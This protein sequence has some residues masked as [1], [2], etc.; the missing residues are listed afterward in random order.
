MWAESQ[1]KNPARKQVAGK[2][3]KSPKGQYPGKPNICRPNTTISTSQVYKLSRQKP[4]SQDSGQSNANLSTQRG[5]KKTSG[6]HEVIPMTASIDIKGLRGLRKQKG[7]PDVTSRGT[8]REGLSRGKPRKSQG[9]SQ[10]ARTQR[11]CP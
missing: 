8:K 2:Q 4:S 11:V 6:D 1:G 10:K 9:L 7:R 3:R 5:L